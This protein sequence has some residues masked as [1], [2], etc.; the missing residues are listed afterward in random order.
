MNATWLRM[1]AGQRASDILGRAGGRASGNVCGAAVGG[2]T[3]GMSGLLTVAAQ[4]VVA[5]FCQNSRWLGCATCLA[6]LLGRVDAPLPP[7]TARAAHLALHSGSEP[8]HA[9]TAVW[10]PRPPGWTLLRVI[11][12]QAPSRLLAGGWSPV[13]LACACHCPGCIRLLCAAK[14][15]TSLHGTRP[16][17]V[18]PACAPESADFLRGR[19]HIAAHACDERALRTHRAG[20]SPASRAQ[21]LSRSPDY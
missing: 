19:P 10:L 11:R 13:L 2:P 6:M 5:A 7:E 15:P 17:R 3:K 12:R 16:C 20:L 14:A 8:R 21:L 1:V 18:Q 4:S 9:A